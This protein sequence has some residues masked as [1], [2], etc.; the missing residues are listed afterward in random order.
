MAGLGTRS[1][2][3]R[4]EIGNSRP[5]VVRACALLDRRLSPSEAV[6]ARG[7]TFAATCC[8]NGWHVGFCAGLEPH[9][10]RRHSMTYKLSPQQSAQWKEGARAAEQVEEEV[11]EDL[12]QRRRD[13]SVAVVLDDG[14]VAFWVSDEG[15]LI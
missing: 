12:E 2:I 8:P 4:A 7:T 5:T 3:E 15:A 1:A 13:A 9:A 10:E 6:E 14:L 11:M